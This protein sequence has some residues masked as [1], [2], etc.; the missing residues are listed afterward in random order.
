[1]TTP[2]PTGSWPPILLFPPNLTV[3]TLAMLASDAD[4]SDGCVWTRLAAR[5]ALSG[6]SGRARP[7]EGL[8]G[9][10]GA[11]RRK[12]PCASVSDAHAIPR[13]SK[14]LHSLENM[15][16]RCY[17]CGGAVSPAPVI[18]TYLGLTRPNS[19]AVRDAESKM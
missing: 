4:A 3:L 12:P 8:R 2:H 1:M 18:S 15:P 11:A 7:V 17:E 16:V 14:H 19:A 5:K 13:L 10:S 9:L 6:T